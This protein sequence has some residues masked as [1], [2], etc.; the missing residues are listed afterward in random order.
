MSNWWGE[1][2]RE[3]E[4]VLCTT[5]EI[6]VCLSIFCGVFAYW[7]LFG[8]QENGATKRIFYSWC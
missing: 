7:L 2:M 3:V 6:K 5:E 4:D 8:F 1:A